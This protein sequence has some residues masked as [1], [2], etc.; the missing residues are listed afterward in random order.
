MVCKTFKDSSKRM[1]NADQVHS[2][3]LQT[4]DC[5]FFVKVLIFYSH[6]IFAAATKATVKGQSSKLPRRGQYT[7]AFEV[8]GLQLLNLFE[9]KNIDWRQLRSH[10]VCSTTW[11]PNPG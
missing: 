11:C 8:S 9:G 7:K 6:K 5:D 2:N 3:F 1:E 4:N 10:V